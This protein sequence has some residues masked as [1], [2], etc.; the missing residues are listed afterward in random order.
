[1]LLIPDADASRAWQLNSPGGKE[2]LYQLAANIFLYAVDKQF[3]RFKGE[4]YLEKPDPKI[5]ADRVIKVARLQYPGNFDPEPGG[6]VRMSAIMHNREKTDLN[7]ETVKLGAGKLQSG[8]YRLAHLT[9]TLPLK[10]DAAMRTDIKTFVVNGGTLVV[11]AA[12][13]SGEFAQS[14]E[15]ELQLIFFGD[16]KQLATPLKPDHPLYTAG[17]NP[18]ADVR[19]RAYAR[20]KLDGDMKHPRLKGIEL[21][22]RLAVIY[23]R[24]DLSV[25]LVGQNVDGIIGYDPAT[26]TA[27]MSRILLYAAK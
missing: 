22:G 26:A 24:E 17:S 8:G 1:M 23:S 13:G 2:E 4:T 12:G 15:Q 19:Y 27:L 7:V 21:D 20:E 25:G 5:K 18:L 6:W 9:G 16:A 14:A 10:L 3:M 11:D